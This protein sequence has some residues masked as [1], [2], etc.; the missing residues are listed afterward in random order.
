M[1]GHVGAAKALLK[2]GANVGAVSSKGL[3]PLHMAVQSGACYYHCHCTPPRD[4]PCL[5]PHVT[6]GF[7][8]RAREGYERLC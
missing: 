3:T 5:P 6:L 7:W 2:A 4:A 8:V 1:K